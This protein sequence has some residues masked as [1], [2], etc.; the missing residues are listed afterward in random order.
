MLN[1]SDGEDNESPIKLEITGYNPL[2]AEQE[3]FQLKLKVAQKK[4]NELTPEN[5]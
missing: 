3:N 4:L 1:D 5:T 2:Q